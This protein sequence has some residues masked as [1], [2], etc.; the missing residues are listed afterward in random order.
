[1]GKR[2]DRINSTEDMRRLL[3]DVLGHELR[4]PLTNMKLAVTSM[5][6]EDVEWDRISQRELLGVI[7]AGIEGL[8]NILGS[9][10]EVTALLTRITE[11][12]FAPVSCIELARSAINEAYPSITRHT[13]QLAAE[14][15]DAK[16]P[17]NKPLVTRA[18]VAL[19]LNAEKFSPPGSEIILAIERE[20][21]WITYAVIDDG[22]GIH[23]NDHQRIF[24]MFVKGANNSTGNPGGNGIGLGLVKAI[25][26]AHG[27]N[28]SVESEPDRGSKFTI[29]LPVSRS[30]V[31]AEI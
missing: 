28:L 14:L 8:T 18:L 3:V 7:D 11:I 16:I 9:M 15:S 20:P 1:M 29:A 23:W 4:I 10:D 27:G 22:V 19:L 6:A 30:L 5:L 25:V 26:D 2:V 24:G 17:A 31:A 12:S 21:E 13:V